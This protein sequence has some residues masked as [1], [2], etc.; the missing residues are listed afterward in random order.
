MRALHSD[1][2]KG[3]WAAVPTPWTPDFKLNVE[4]L[5]DNLAKYASC[6]VTGVY[7]TDSDG[8][9]YALELHQF[10]ELAAHFGRALS[11]TS[12][13]GAMGVTWSHTAGIIDRIKASLD[14]GIPNVHVAFPYWM[15]LAKPDVPR[16]FEDLAEQAPEARWIH[17]RTERAH[18]LLN[19]KD[20]TLLKQNYPDQLVGTKLGTSNITEIVEIVS[21]APSVAHFMG[22]DSC[23]VFGALAGAQGV[24]S[25][26]VNTLPRWTLET[27][28]LCETKQW[29][30]AVQRQCKLIRWEKEAIEKLRAKGHCHGIIGKARTG[31][32][33]FLS[34]EGLTRAP[35]YPVAP[36]DLAELRHSFDLFWSEEK[37]KER[38]V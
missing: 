10:R 34:D 20:Y 4:H 9:F 17:Y 13:E 28:H 2:L 22:G 3:V 11:R 19:G 37:E 12:L 5:E 15:P 6:G 24:Y 23:A 36:S 30:E 7:T 8:E 1:Q 38:F 25:Y 33:H 27:W 26:W 31:L 35:Y 32:T 16:F 29:A 18:I 14:A 21:N